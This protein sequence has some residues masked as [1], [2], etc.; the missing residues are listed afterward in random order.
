[1]KETTTTTLPSGLDATTDVTNQAADN[2]A[3]TETATPTPTSSPAAPAEPAA[4]APPKLTLW[5]LMRKD[6]PPEPD[7]DDDEDDTDRVLSNPRQS[8]WDIA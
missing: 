4:P 7:D 5:E 6:V 1:M 3:E 8:I 2:K